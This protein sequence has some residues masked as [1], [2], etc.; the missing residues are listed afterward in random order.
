[1]KILALVG[2]PRKMG[3]TDLLIERFLDCARTRGYKTEKL[4]LY[5]Y[6]ISLCTDCRSYNKGDYVCCIEEE[7]Q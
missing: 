7:M 6:T 3:N 4:H 1:M 5:D 2:S